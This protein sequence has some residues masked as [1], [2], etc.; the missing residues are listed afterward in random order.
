MSARCRSPA[1]AVAVALGLCA[2]AG[3]S[4]PADQAPIVVVV[5]VEGLRHDYPDRADTP[6]LARLAAEGGRA[7]RVL[8]VF[9]A[10]SLPNQAALVTGRLPGASGLVNNRLFDRATGRTFEGE[11]E[12]A[13][14]LFLAEPIWV[15]AE[16]QGVATGGINW[17]GAEARYAGVGA[18]WISRLDE[19]ADDEDRVREL[20]DVIAGRHAVSPRLVLV[21]LLALLPRPAT[22]PNHR[23]TVPTTVAGLRARSSHVDQWE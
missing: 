2:I 12:E 8:P 16:R 17:F 18:S 4:G 3:C 9:P 22:A 13:E 5:C 20:V 15:T 21:Y 14:A 6:V 23:R 10:N 11:P 1:F 7:V 19:E